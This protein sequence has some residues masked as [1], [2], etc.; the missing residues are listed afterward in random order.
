MIPQRY[1]TTIIFLTLLKPY[2]NPKCSEI[3]GP[4]PDDD[5]CI[6]NKFLT[7]ILVW[8]INIYVV[9]CEGL[10]LTFQKSMT[11]VS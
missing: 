9:R 11:I 6:E 2:F 3:D 10:V 1:D 4:C 5:T 7:P 8:G